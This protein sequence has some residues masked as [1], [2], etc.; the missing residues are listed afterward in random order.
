MAK[1]NVKLID[2][3]AGSAGKFYGI[4]FGAIGKG[5]LAKDKKSFKGI[6]LV[7][8]GVDEKL[9][10]SLIDAEKLEVMSDAEVKALKAKVAKV[11]AK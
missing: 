4:Q 2:V 5:V 10:E 6:T 3:V 9:V 7:A 11:E 1:V 8:E